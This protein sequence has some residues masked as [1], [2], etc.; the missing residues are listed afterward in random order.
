[1]VQN[2]RVELHDSKTCWRDNDAKSIGF[3]SKLSCVRVDR[4]LINELE[5]MAIESGSNVRICLHGG[6]NSKFHEMVICQHKDRILP[7]KKHNLKDKSFHVIKG[8]LAIYTFNTQGDIEDNIILDGKMTFMYRV[9]QGIFHADFPA[10]DVVIHHESTTGPFQGEGES[11]YAPWI[12]RDI[13]TKDLLAYRDKL[14][15]TSQD[16]N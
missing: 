4:I 2:T 14:Y 1:M 7:P 16:L 3:F 5:V 8:K 9:G 11:I 6:P 13:S 12:P 15:I 10:S